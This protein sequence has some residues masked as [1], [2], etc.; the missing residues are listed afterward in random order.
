MTILLFYDRKISCLSLL[1]TSVTCSEFLLPCANSH[2]SWQSS[3][4]LKYVIYQNFTLSSE[5]EGK[6]IWIVFKGDGR[7]LFL[8][9][10]MLTHV[11]LHY[12]SWITSLYNYNYNNNKYTNWDCSHVQITPFHYGICSNFL[13]VAYFLR[14]SIR[15]LKFSIHFYA[16]FIIPIW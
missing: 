4:Q 1:V 10:I 14:V 5:Q 11:N 3:A 8:A 12:I 13:Q 7:S 2:F 16:G 15:I 6:R 9:T